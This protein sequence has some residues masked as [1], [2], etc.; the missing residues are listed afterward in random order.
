MQ[1]KTK[2]IE[3]RIGNVDK[4]LREAVKRRFPN[5]PKENIE[6]VLYFATTPGAVGR[7]WDIF[8]SKADEKDTFFDQAAYLAVRAHIRHKYTEYDEL[9]SE[10]NH[11]YDDDI[12][13]EIRKKIAPDIE[14]KL[15]EWQ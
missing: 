4:R 12:K 9:L 5:I 10:H 2:G 14:T 7:S 13:Y 15:M 8:S 11:S 6:S 1:S 3:K